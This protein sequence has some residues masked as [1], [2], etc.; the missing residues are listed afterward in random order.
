MNT[1]PAIVPPAIVWTIEEEGIDRVILSA[2]PLARVCPDGASVV[3]NVFH[4]ERTY[5]DHSRPVH[6]RHVV[7]PFRVASVSLVDADG[8]RGKESAAVR[9]G[10]TL[11]SGY[12]YA[13]VDES[14][15]CVD[16]PDAP[17]RLYWRSTSSTAWRLDGFAED[18]PDGARRAM[19]DVFESA[20]TFAGDNLPH[21]WQGAE[22]TRAK[23]R[24][25]NAG[26]A[27]D[28]AREEVKQARADMRASERAHAK[29]LK[30]T[31][32]SAPSLAS[33]GTGSARVE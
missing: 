14:R 26:N 24:V 1:L 16:G 27:L 28:D 5:H 18:L 17:R 25:E 9:F 3:I 22:L 20:A 30:K 23:N 15:G 8:N 6:E 21:L 12:C 4:D 19:Y 33:S 2:A 13:R 32:A 10:A 31:R 11:A 29:A 7:E